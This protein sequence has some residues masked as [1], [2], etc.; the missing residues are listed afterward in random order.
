ME[1]S[2]FS[3]DDHMNKKLESYL[4]KHLAG[5]ESGLL[6]ATELASTAENPAEKFCF[7][8]LRDSIV[9]EKNLL[10]EMI[11]EA[12]LDVSTL[13]RATGAAAGHLGL[14]RLSMDGADPGELGRFEM[15]EMLALGIHGKRLLWTLMHNLALSST[16]WRRHD[17]AK[18][19]DDASQQGAS[20]E[21]YRTEAAQLVFLSNPTHEQKAT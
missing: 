12:G 4:N 9:R 8:G 6:V 21:I 5:A 10:A 18:L 2:H 15:I 1:P 11:A 17:F 7:L 16:L 14:W 3:K 19:I 20:I 13:R